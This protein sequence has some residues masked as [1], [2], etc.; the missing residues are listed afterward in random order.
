MTL[1]PTLGNVGR[2]SLDNVVLR[3]TA[4]IVAEIVRVDDSQFGWKNL[5]LNLGIVDVVKANLVSHAMVFKALTLGFI[6]SYINRALTTTLAITP[7]FA[8]R[9]LNV[10]SI[11]LLPVSAFWW[12]IYIVPIL[13]TTLAVGLVVKVFR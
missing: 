2:G 7:G 4:P 9:W 3:C 12:V 1:T 8:Q 11:L 10:L 13:W 6:K 5:R